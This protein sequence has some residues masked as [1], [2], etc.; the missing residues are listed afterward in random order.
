MNLAALNELA[1]RPVRPGGSILAAD[2][3]IGT[4]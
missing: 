2:E 1:E 3:S 4:G